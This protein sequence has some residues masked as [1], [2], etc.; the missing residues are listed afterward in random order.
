MGDIFYKSWSGAAYFGFETFSRAVCLYA[1]AIK[2]GGQPK[3]L[4]PARKARAGIAK[5]VKQGAINL[6]HQLYLL[7]AEDEVVKGN[8]RQAKSL[9]NKAITT[10]VRGG[11]LCDA[12][13]ANERYA[14]YLESL[15]KDKDEASH[16]MKEAINYFSE[17]GAARKVRL[18]SEQ[19]SQ[20]LN[21]PKG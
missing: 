1:M 6:L 17:W 14:V 9:F 3:Y 18:L 10:A 15:P 16:H 19:H 2:S 4:K 13:I 7:D 12:G 11:F 20:I 5:W 21:R 8:E